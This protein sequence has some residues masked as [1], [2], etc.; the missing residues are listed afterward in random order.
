MLFAVCSIPFSLLCVQVVHEA[1]PVAIGA[2]REA[3]GE[4]V[5]VRN[6]MDAEKNLKKVRSGEAHAL[7]A[8]GK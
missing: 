7:Q 1:T 2:G 8:L 5:L 6:I 4:G 3:G